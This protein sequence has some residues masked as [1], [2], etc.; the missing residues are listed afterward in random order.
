[1]SDIQPGTTKRP[2]LPSLQ[3]LRA[4]A[5]MMIFAGHAFTQYGSL[6]GWGVSAFFVLSGFLMCYSYYDRELSI[7]PLHALAFSVGKIKK[8][9]WLH[10]FV[11]IWV[12]AVRGQSPT[13]KKVLLNL[14]L[15][16][17]W[18]PMGDVYFSM[19]G[20]SWYLC[21]IAVVYALF[22]Y[23]LA[24]LKRLKTNR[25][26]L[27]HMSAVYA[28]MIIAGFVSGK[29][30][31]PK[32]ISNNF[33]KWFTYIFPLFRLGEF[34]IG[35]D[36]GFVFLQRG[37]A[38]ESD[39]IPDGKIHWGLSLAELGAVTLI[40]VPLLL[41]INKVSIFAKSW[42]GSTL[43]YIPASCAMVYLFAINKGAISAGLTRIKMLVFIGTLSPYT[44]LIHT[45]VLRLCEGSIRIKGGALANA[46]VVVGAA[47]VLT[48]MAGYVCRLILEQGH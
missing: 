31:V 2:R 39:G 48:Q 13:L 45:Q 29:L 24:R 47:F 21:V 36:L 17:V 9:Y 27:L 5:A 33:A 1:M 44:F 41:R 18:V 14:S 16:K 37:F 32:T 20:V 28:T 10:L 11:L 7:K 8:L 42:F 40:A 23:I 19:G 26:A 38:A 43:M 22:P 25:D 12:L 30:N 15:L 35:C 4:L 3:V 6:G 46:M 34:I